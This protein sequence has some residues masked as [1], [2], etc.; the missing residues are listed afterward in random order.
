MNV[1]AYYDFTADEY[2]QT[3]FHELDHKPVDCSILSRFAELTKDQ[4]LV[5]D[6]GC[7]PGHIGNYLQ[8]QGATVQGIDLSAEM[9]QEAHRRCP[10]IEFR[11]GDMLN[12]DFNDNHLA[13]IVAFYA[14]VHLS[15][16]ELE[17]VLGEFKRVIKPGGY[18]LFSF[19]VG[20]ELIRVEK[21]LG[22]RTVAVD[23]TFF[24]ADEVIN[25]AGA[26]GWI[27]EEAIIRYPY[28]DIEYPS[29]R[30]YILARKD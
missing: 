28:R 6:V 4:G 1:Q 17:L 18:L 9:V 26:I 13:G 12:L 11:Q 22:G 10:A 8:K 7:G 20:N 24:D 29:K 2:G 15:L 25:R 27:I 21:S 23:F 3:F 19:H 30:A 16:P 5:C 14:I